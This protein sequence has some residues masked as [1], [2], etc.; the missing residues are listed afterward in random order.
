MTQSTSRALIESATL[1]ETAAALLL[2]SPRLT[3]SQIMDL[4]DIGDAEFRGMTGNSAT[5]RALLEQRRNGELAPPQA[6]LKTCPGC[7]EWYLPYAGAR[8]CSDECGRIVR[9]RT[10]GPVP[11]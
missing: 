6:E 3:V 5:I 1:V 10:A 4:L 11:R 7:G 2:R 9:I 8:Y